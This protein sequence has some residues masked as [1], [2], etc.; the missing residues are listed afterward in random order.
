VGGLCEELPE[1]FPQRSRPASISAE[2]QLQVAQRSL[3]KVEACVAALEN[4]LGFLTLTL[5][6][7]IQALEDKS[8]VNKDEL[9]KKLKSM[10]M[11]DGVAD[12]RVDANLLQKK[13][14]MLPR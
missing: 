3:Q 11:L 2:T 14:R 8:V 6:M 13:L 10:D 5:R 1:T 4:D 9:R 12:G 7:L